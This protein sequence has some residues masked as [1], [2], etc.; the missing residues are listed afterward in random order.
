M[1]MV[2]LRLYKLTRRD[3]EH[4]AYYYV[5]LDPTFIHSIKY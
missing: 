5:V 2:A 4:H 1:F 3:Y